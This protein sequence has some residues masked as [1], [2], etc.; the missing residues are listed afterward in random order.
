MAEEMRES[1]YVIALPDLLHVQGKALMALGEVEA[2]AEALEKGA[3]SARGTGSR[4]RLWPIL[5]TLAELEA[6]RGDEE[7]A[8]AHRRERREVVGFIRDHIGD[9]ELRERFLVVAGSD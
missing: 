9:E 8:A 2:S 1:N 6:G 3:S 7:R 5:T 4:L